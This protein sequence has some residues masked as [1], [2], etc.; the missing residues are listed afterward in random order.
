[1]SPNS[2]QNLLSDADARV[3]FLKQS[4]H[5]NLFPDELI[6]TLSPH[7]KLNHFPESHE[8]T[9]EGE[10]HSELFFLIK[11]NV[12]VYAGGEFI[13]TLRRQGDICG[14]M[15]LVTD[16]PKFSTDIA[17]TDVEMFSLEINELC[18]NPE[19]NSAEL[20]ELLRSLC[21]SILID[22]LAL[23]TTKAGHFEENRKQ[24]H[25]A[26]EESQQAN[27]AR[28]NFLANISHEIRTPMHGV[29]GMS[30][31]L[32]NTEMTR[33][34]Q[35][36]TRMIQH[37]AG[38][39][40]NIIN[41]IVNISDLERGDL[42]IS[43][44]SF[45]L[46]QLMERLDVETRSIAENKSLD[47]SKSIDPNI[48]RLLRG[49]PTRLHQILMYLI[50]NAIKFT[51][52]GSIRV[53]VSLKAET[54][55][56]VQLIFSVTDTG[57]GIEEAQF[58]RIFEPFTQ[59]DESTSRK[60]GGIGLGLA[61]SKKLV[62]LMGGQIGFDTTIDKGS[63]FWFRLEI[64]R[65]PDR[66]KA[67]NLSA[68]GLRESDKTFLL[69]S[70][71]GIP[72][73][74]LVVDHDPVNRLVAVK[75]LQRMG[76]HVESIDSGEKALCIL[77]LLHFD[78]VLMNVYLPGNS[79]L[80]IVRKIRQR[81][82]TVINPAIPILGMASHVAECSQNKIVSAGLTGLIQKPLTRQNLQIAVNQWLSES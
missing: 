80:K 50:G 16:R 62:E 71:S 19:I 69:D 12:S 21:S 15:C 10:T 66:R 49:D 42:Y 29:I 77:E 46:I 76:C 40:Q 28:S 14:E 59:V 44:G 33:E 35:D 27:H 30:D 26:I 79:G 31:L 3:E 17:G 78:L 48:P 53:N 82:S 39:L 57:I 81:E 45:D 54:E 32:L 11:G 18:N 67:K 9:R 25:E 56:A 7:L 5:F 8:I 36:Y 13:L 23:T 41:D 38:N 65:Q 1:M 37:S 64:N 74:I 6:Q 60:F 43:N 34:Q 2:F 51:H 61:V 20:K 58:D 55:Q 70:V 72:S 47:F 22:K 52:Q 68:D 4:R 24:L 73:R 63:I 75:G